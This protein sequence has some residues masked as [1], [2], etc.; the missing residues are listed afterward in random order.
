MLPRRHSDVPASGK[1]W[2]LYC[3]SCSQGKHEHWH[4]NG[5]QASWI[6]A[7]YRSC[8]KC[9]LP[10]TWNP[11]AQ[12]P[13]ICVKFPLKLQSRW[14]QLLACRKLSWVQSHSRRLERNWLQLACSSGNPVIWT[15][16]MASALCYFWT[17]LQLVSLQWQ[18]STRKGINIFRTVSGHFM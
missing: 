17:V 6:S 1:I 9:Q 13:E 10:R 11:A 2:P 15:H 3:P 14:N 4:V 5:H 18:N 8:G 16:V 12:G 7:L